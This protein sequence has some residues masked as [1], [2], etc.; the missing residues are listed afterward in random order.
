M[1][2]RRKTTKKRRRRKNRL[3]W[4]C[5]VESGWVKLKW[6]LVG[7]N[8][9]GSRDLGAHFLFFWIFISNWCNF[10]EN[11]NYSRTSISPFLIQLRL[12]S[13]EWTTTT[14]KNTRNDRMSAIA[15]KRVRRRKGEGGRSRKYAAFVH[16]HY[17]HIR[18]LNMFINARLYVDSMGNTIWCP[19]LCD[20]L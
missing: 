8:H 15:R 14:V 19:L 10:D 18:R 11:L 17:R 3:W 9:M 13:P 1:K 7:P 16:S 4:W 2:Q 12:T 5:H 20:P 6:I